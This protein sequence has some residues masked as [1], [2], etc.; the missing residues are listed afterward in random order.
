MPRP[1]Q[2]YPS[3][4]GVMSSAP[5]LPFA[6][7]DNMRLPAHR[8][9]HLVRFHPYSRTRPSL[10]Q[11]RLMVRLSRDS[12]LWFPSRS[13][14]PNQTAVDYRFP[15]SPQ[16]PFRGVASIVVRKP[17]V[18]LV[19]VFFNN[20][21]MARFS[22]QYSQKTMS[23]PKASRWHPPARQSRCSDDRNLKPLL[24]DFP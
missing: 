19:F 2:P 14:S 22:P 18:G 6:A 3:F 8:H 23:K 9:S 11:E 15:E 13:I 1:I 12:R 4:A 10:D 7:N 5:F 20:R 16:G 17:I 24:V 21:I